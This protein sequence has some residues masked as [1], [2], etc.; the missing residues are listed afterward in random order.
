MSNASKLSLVAACAMGLA[1]TSAQAAVQGF[2]IALTDV[3]FERGSN[4]SAE[5]AAFGI[6]PNQLP[7]VQLP[8][9]GHYNETAT[10]DYTVSDT[11]PPSDKEVLWQTFTQIS[12]NGNPFF[13]EN[14]VLGPES[15]DDIWSGILNIT[16]L[17]DAQLK[18]LRAVLVNHPVF[19]TGG[20]FDYAYNPPATASDRTHG[21]FAVGSS[22]DL[23][24]ENFG[25][26]VDPFAAFDSIPAPDGPNVWSLTFS[27]TVVPEPPTWLML[28]AGGGVLLLVRGMARRPRIGRQVSA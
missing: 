25:S 4:L 11:L 1:V 2:S 10:G 5:A 28:M 13:T 24:I 20:E 8:N 15:Q 23:S 16:G 9:N 26:Y 7:A 21:T 18:F 3:T 27:A 17:T 19:S 12:L 14:A 22:K 6:P